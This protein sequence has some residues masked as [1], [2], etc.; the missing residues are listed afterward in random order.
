MSDIRAITGRIAFLNNLKRDLALLL[1][2]LEAAKTH[3]YLFVVDFAAIY[4]YVYRTAGPAWMHAGDESEEQLYARC[5]LALQLV[6]SGQIQPLLLI[7]PYA[8]ELSNHLKMLAQLVDRSTAILQPSELRTRLRAMIT[9]SDEFMTFAQLESE[10][11]SVADSARL[12]AALNIGRQYFPELY[13]AVT[14]LSGDSTERLRRLFH[15]HI[16]QDADIIIPQS[17][18][19]DYSS[20]PAVDEWY[21]KIRSARRT[22][23]MFQTFTDAMACEYIVA[24]NAMLNEE[25][26]VVVFVAPSLNLHQVLKEVDCI[27]VAGRPPFGAVRDLPYFVL[28]LTHKNDRQRVQESLHAV[29]QLLDI[30]SRLQLGAPREAAEV[31]SQARDMWKRSENLLFMT[32]SPLPPKHRQEAAAGDRMFLDILRTLHDAVQTDRPALEEEILQSLNTFRVSIGDLEKE[33]P[34]RENVEP[35]DPF[36][37]TQGIGHSGPSVS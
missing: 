25:H 23:R 31:V 14:S 19:L 32:E 33:V 28:A 10:G 2:D 29:N 35:Q 4:A 27:T 24:A 34:R 5:Q 16:L 7:P 18:N 17:K 15:S 36:S 21:A 26:R 1:T 12:Q 3:E 8:R 37:P 6:F 13:S 11:T 9:A 30:Y 20:R 22:E